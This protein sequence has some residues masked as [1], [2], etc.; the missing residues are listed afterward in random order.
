MRLLAWLFGDLYGR[1][2]AWPRVRAEHL[3]REPVCAACGR[4]KDLEVHHI[5]PYSTHPELE[6]D[7]GNLITLCRDPCHFY[8]AHL[9]NWSHSNPSIRED[10][11][12]YRERIREA[13]K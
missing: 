6:L 12:R 4:S 10:A 11:A 8:L 5:R 7:D 13:Q 9:M 2:G 1:S 3:R